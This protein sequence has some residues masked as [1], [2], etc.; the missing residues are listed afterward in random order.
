MFLLPAIKP[1]GLIW[2]LFF[3][4]KTSKIFVILIMIPVVLSITTRNPSFVIVKIKLSIKVGLR[5][6]L[7]LCF[8]FKLPASVLSEK[9]SLLLFEKKID[10]L[11]DIKSDVLDRK[12][13]VRIA[14]GWVGVCQIKFP[15]SALIA[16]ISP[17]ELEK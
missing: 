15:V 17:I 6:E 10:L 5:S 3:L 11:S 8:Q 9:N 4:L 16:V 1:S 2:D 13:P 14:D 7:T 12:L